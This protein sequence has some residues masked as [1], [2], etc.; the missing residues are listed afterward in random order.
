MSSYY[1][2]EDDKEYA[3]EIYWEAKG[4]GNASPSTATPK[5]EYIRD[6]QCAKCGRWATAEDVARHNINH[7]NCAD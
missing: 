4:L 1:D 7:P 2:Y 3:R 5:K 6:T